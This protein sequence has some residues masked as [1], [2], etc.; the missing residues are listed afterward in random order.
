MIK[1]CVCGIEKLQITWKHLRCHGLTTSEYRKLYPNAAL[2]DESIKL[3]GERNPFFGK[4]HTEELK[5]WQ[6][7]H[8]TGKKCPSASIKISEKWKDPDG[9][10]RK[11]MASDEYREI[12]SKVIQAY[13]DSS[14]SNAHR[15]KNSEE[16]KRRRPEYSDKIKEI[17][18]TPE[19][20]KKSSAAL[21][22][23]WATMTH[24]VK[25]K[26]IDKQISSMM[27]NNTLSSKGELRLLELLKQFFHTIKHG[28][29]FHKSTT[30]APT[31]WNIDFYIPEINTYV[32]FDGVYWH[33][34]DR[35]IELICEL[36]TSRNK[37]IYN[38]WVKDRLQDEWFLKTN[39]RLIRITDLEFKSSP[40]MCLNKIWGTNVI[41]TSS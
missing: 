12:M 21:K 32:Q 36:Q 30:G 24:E 29:W 2:Q 1:C 35:P 26:R 13:W 14:D 40:D 4:K 17:Q 5:Q 6:R 37:A 19:Y 8:F 41:S 23:I 38:N 34:L 16:F 39:K 7:E 18:K 15:Q 28:V 3:K 25:Q 22:Q 33:G 27:N 11:M 9:I 31:S 10:Y 20:R